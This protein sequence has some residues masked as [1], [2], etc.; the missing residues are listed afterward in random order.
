MRSFVF[1]I[2]LGLFGVLI[3]VSLGVWQLQRLEWKRSIL[4]E[5]DSRIGAD[6]VS[7]PATP[8]PLSDKYL[9][10]TTQGKF[11]GDALHVLGSTKAQGAGYRV[12]QRFETSVG[13]V[14][15]DRG[16]I[17]L[18]DKTAEL[19][20]GPMQITGNLHWPQDS[21]KY[22]PAPDIA[23]NIWFAR[24][25]AAMS[26]ALGTSPVMIV[27]KTE[28]VPSPILTQTPVTTSGIPNNHLQY[29]ITWFSL[30]LVWLGMTG[31][32]MWRIRRSNASSYN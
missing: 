25:V 4:A 14:L 15:V 10:V 31:F 8:D 18:E 23:K 26:K 5:I 28:S 2:L 17:V 13:D 24:D 20:S 29:A 11:V 7:L 12:I 32:L 22:T 3:L 1:P 27:A 9:P 6:P 30:T 21:D 16:F 19:P